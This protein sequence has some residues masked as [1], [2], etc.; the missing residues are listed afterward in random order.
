M[1]RQDG[2]TSVGMLRQDSIGNQ[3]GGKVITH[4]TPE[5]VRPPPGVRPPGGVRPPSPPRKVGRSP[6]RV[7]TGPAEETE[8]LARRSVSLLGTV[9]ELELK[10]PLFDHAELDRPARVYV[11]KKSGRI[12]EVLAL[13]FVI[14]RQANHRGIDLV[15]YVMARLLRGR[16]LETCKQHVNESLTS[17]APELVSPFGLPEMM[18]YVPPDPTIR[19]VF[20]GCVEY[21]TCEVLEGAARLAIAD[22]RHVVRKSDVTASIADDYE[23]DRL[24]KR[25]ADLVNR[26]SRKKTP[27]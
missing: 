20:R 25:S 10:L 13:L 6:F 16:M 24:F 15:Y 1:L 26:P 4:L 11:A 7:R 9:K 21:V 14:G 23:L 12:A 8:A 18:G 3:P 5:G 27:S 19:R 22:G 17:G 2:S